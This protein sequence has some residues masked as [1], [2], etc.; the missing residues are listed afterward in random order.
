VV[1]NRYVGSNLAHQGGKIHNAKER[2]KYF[3]WDYDLEYNILGIPK[4]DISL[5]LHVT[6]EVSQKLV[7]KKGAREYLHG[8][9]RD[10]HEDDLRHL[11]DAE[12]AYLEIAELFK[13][14]RLIECVEKGTILPPQKIHQKIWSILNLQS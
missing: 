13:E 8:R 5:I 14:Y 9:R 12:K 1:C 4:P 11:C 7:D 3:A 2:E 6:P 10:I